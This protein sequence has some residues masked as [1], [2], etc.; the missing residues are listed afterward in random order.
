[1]HVRG[2][3]LQ[4]ELINLELKIDRVLMQILTGN[5][6]TEVGGEGALVRERLLGIDVY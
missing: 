3:S 6:V 2:G 5:D 4:F 1:M